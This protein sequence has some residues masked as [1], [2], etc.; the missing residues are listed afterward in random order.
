M[1]DSTTTFQ[2]W[3][4]GR[5]ETGMLG[6]NN[7]TDYS[8]PVQIPG[9]WTGFNKGNIGAETTL[10]DV[11][12][13]AKADGTLWSWGDN[14]YGAL[15]LNNVV[16]YSSPVQ[17][18]GTDWGGSFIHASKNS[19]VIKSS[20]ELYAI[21][22]INYMGSLGINASGTNPNNNARSSPTQIP[23]SWKEV[24][25]ASNSTAAIKT[26]GTM[27]SWGYNNNGQL[28]QTGNAAVSSPVQIPGTTWSK[29]GGGYAQ[30]FAVKTDGTAWAWGQNT[31]GNLG[32]NNRTTYSSPIQIPGTTWKSISGAEKST[33]GTKTDGTLW[34]WGLNQ[35]GTFGTNN[36]T[37]ASSPVQVP[38]T[39][40]ND[41]TT[42]SYGMVSSKTDGT[43]WVWGLNDYGQLAQNNRN[44]DNVGY[45]SPI[46]IPGKDVTFISKGTKYGRAFV[47]E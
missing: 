30:F 24:A 18:P 3:T 4:W 17:V 19:F 9:S 28:A 37:N 26:D 35:Y 2:W 1:S 5:N 6:Q 13:G 10:G 46:Q 23:G 15:G 25:T 43:L 8:S 12:I 39:T 11:N 29:V 22:G 41:V 45:S 44:P 36:T 21:G 20:G 16:Q 42:S 34:V 32:Q 40:W 31:T 14:E 27:W 47:E 7:L 38:G 33:A